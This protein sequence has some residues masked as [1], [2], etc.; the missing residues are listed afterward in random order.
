M[1]S[2]RPAIAR[3]DQENRARA[4]PAPGGDGR[5]VFNLPP[6]SAEPPADSA[7]PHPWVLLARLIR[8]HGR[9]G[10]IVAEVLTDFPERFHQRSRLFLIPPERVGTQPREV[11]LD[12]FWFLRSRIVFKF[13]A[14]DS[15]ND[16]EALRGYDVAIPAAE[17]APL[18]PGS[19]YVSDLIG[20][21]VFDLNRDGAEAGEIVDLDRASSNA[22]LLVLRSAQTGSRA[23]SE[24]LIPFVRNYLV[25]IDLPAR[26]V[27]MRLPEGLLEINAPIREE[28][29]REMAGSE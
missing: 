9:H 1:P 8:P 23:A 13:Q 7:R 10:E 26:R 19:V 28:E 11:H 2:P 24:L 22:E 29:K 21:R 15:I 17:R 18:E 12:N 6:S 16:A 5:A 14:V 20:C 25:R 4:V 3:E 27:E